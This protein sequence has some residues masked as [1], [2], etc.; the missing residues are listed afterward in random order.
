MGDVRAV[1]EE[2]AS[3][4][5]P[6]TTSKVC[7]AHESALETVECKLS[8][9]VQH[10]E[11]EAA[12]ARMR[13]WCKRKEAPGHRVSWRPPKRYRLGA[14][15]FLYNLDNQVRRALPLQGLAS[16]VRDA[17]GQGCW[18]DW[19]RWRHLT[20]CVDQGSDG[21]AACSFLRHLS[22]NL[23]V[24]TDFSH[25]GQNDF[26]DGLRD[27][28]L[29]S[30]WVLMLV[31]FNCEH[32]PW[33]DDLRYHQIL[34]S[35]QQ[36]CAHY[37]PSTMELFQHHLPAIQEDCAKVEGMLD[38]EL[39]EAQEKVLWGLMGAGWKPKGHKT[40][41][42]RFFASLDKAKTFLPYWHMS[43][44][45]YEHLCLETGMLGSQQVAKLRLRSE[46]ADPEGREGT[47]STSSARLNIAEKALRSAAQNAIVLATLMLGEP[48]H[49]HLTAAIVEVGRPLHIWHKDQNHQLRSAPE[50][51]K[52]LVQMTTGQFFEHVRGIFGVL[53]SVSALQNIGLD[54]RCFSGAT[55]CEKML[56]DEGSAGWQDDLSDIFGDLAMALGGRR[57]VR[58]AFMW[59]GW[60]LRMA[61]ILAE[62]PMADDVV[63]EFKRDAEAVAMLRAIEKDA[64]LR[65]LCRRTSFNDVAV[66]QYEMAPLVRS[67]SDT[68]CRL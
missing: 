12:K 6:I 9:A 29:W 21:L 8:P 28:S 25:G 47:L 41:L 2:C 57:L 66:Q 54:M 16:F 5:V 38:G 67:G 62:G 46:P 22:L 58:C 51:L 10:Q 18:G 20:L 11:K 56:P 53:F 24:V 13:M 17:E 42:N 39:G 34:E 3:L 52:W 32:G 14:K 63:Q 19:R 50:S 33:D 48:W 31:V 7:Q 4:L 61:G 40:N 15:H 44:C 49:R 55:G 27:T 68:Y 1:F 35:W 36:A 26:Y 59:R 37:A 30:F 45:K 65:E 64:A 23:C 60:P 43:L